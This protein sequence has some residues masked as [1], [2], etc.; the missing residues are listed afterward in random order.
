MTTL[1][2]EFCRLYARGLPAPEAAL[3]AGYAPGTAERCAGEILTAPAVKAWLARHNAS[4]S[5]FSAQDLV[6]MRQRLM[7]LLDD[8]DPRIALSANREINR[9]LKQFPDIRLEEDTV[10]VE[11]AAEPEQNTEDNQGEDF[12]NLQEKALQEAGHEY[13]SIIND[14]HTYA[15][16]APPPEELAPLTFTQQIR[17]I[18]RRQNEHYRQKNKKHPHRK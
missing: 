13:N 15:P 4:T 8:K 9:L 1:Q 3:S 5:L 14:M 6:K 12:R 10:F 17:L 16:Y 18:G 2:R 11:T 7:T